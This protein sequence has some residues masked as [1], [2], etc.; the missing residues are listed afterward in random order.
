MPN[1]KGRMGGY[2]LGPSGDCI[3]PNCGY[4]MPHGR[5]SPCN[6]LKCPKCGAMMTR[7]R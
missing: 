6:Q 3:C 2:G 5:G 1:G 4:T 7:T